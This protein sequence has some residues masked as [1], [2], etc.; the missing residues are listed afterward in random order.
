MA[1]QR[2]KWVHVKVTEQERAG[3]Q[4]QA[5]AAELTLADL[6]RQR[7]GEA[8]PVGRDPIRRRAARRADPEL[9]AALGRI[10]SNLNQIGRWANTYKSKAEAVQVLAALVSI[11]QL[12][13]SYR[14]RVSE[15]KSPTGKAEDM[16][17][18]G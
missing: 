11:E 18:A 17:D 7:L 8:K 3:W 6:I 13:S 4:A 9:L 15:A 16:D 10:G 14:P 1:E 2:A 5:E 12:L